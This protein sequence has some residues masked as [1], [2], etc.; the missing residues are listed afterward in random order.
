MF[1]IKYKKM[2]TAHLQMPISE[3]SIKMEIDVEIG[4][5]NNNNKVYF[6]ISFYLINLIE[7]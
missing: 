6:T 3:P 7:I 5:N 4:L 2:D 1:L